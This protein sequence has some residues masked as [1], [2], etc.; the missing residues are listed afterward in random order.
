MFRFTSMAVACAASL[1]FAATPD[2]ISASGGAITITPIDHATLEIA[3]AGTVI[4]VDPTAQGSYTGLPAPDLI[5]ITD[6]HGDHLDPAT[7]AKVK[8]AD[9]KIVAPAAAAPK[10][11]NAIVMANGETKTVAGVSL[12]AV[13]MYNLTR[14]PSAGQL[15]HTKA[16]ATATS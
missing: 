7:V 8:K 13:P 10:L 14:G 11:D 3:H 1:A 12:E 16:A 5:L 4:L 2:S 9:T 15:Y 6:I